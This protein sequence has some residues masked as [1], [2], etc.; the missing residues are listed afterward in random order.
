MA[1]ECTRAPGEPVFSVLHAKERQAIGGIQGTGSQPRSRALRIDGKIALAWETNRLWT[2]LFVPSVPGV[3][4]RWHVMN[5]SRS[6]R[7]QT[8]LVRLGQ[9]KAAAGDDPK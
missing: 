2:G 4:R 6:S 3:L 9:L 8:F 1:P 5:G 7:L